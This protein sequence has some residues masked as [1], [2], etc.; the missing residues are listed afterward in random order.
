MGRASNTLRRSTYNTYFVIHV[1]QDMACHTGV[2][3]CIVDYYQMATPID[4]RIAGL[5]DTDRLNI[6]IISFMKVHCLCEMHQIV[7]KDNIVFTLQ[8]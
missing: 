7:L 5:K 4:L 2:K 8:L 3:I 1:H 6:G